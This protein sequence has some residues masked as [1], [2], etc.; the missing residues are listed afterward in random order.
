MD[1]EQQQ[2]GAMEY[3]VVDTSK[4]KQKGNEQQNVSNLL[5]INNL[6]ISYFFHIIK[7]GG[8]QGKPWLLQ[9]SHFNNHLKTGFCLKY[10]LKHIHIALIML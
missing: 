8:T 7:Y 3:A 4:K 2:Q 9:F 1:S 10:Q 5:R 6:Q